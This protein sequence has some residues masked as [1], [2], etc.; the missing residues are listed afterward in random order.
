[1]GKGQVPGLQESVKQLVLPVW[2]F[3]AQQGYRGP[4]FG[5]R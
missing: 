5:V 2:E 4:G 3:L 1:M